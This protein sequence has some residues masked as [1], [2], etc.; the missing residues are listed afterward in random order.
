[1]FE[2]EN[3]FDAGNASY[4]YFELLKLS[5]LSALNVN[6]YLA[7]MYIEAINQCKSAALL[8]QYGI[9]RKYHNRQYNEF[10]KFADIVEHRNAVPIMELC[11]EDFKVYDVLHLSLRGNTNL[12]REHFLRTA[13]RRAAIER[14]L[15]LCFMV[16]A[17]NNGK[18]FGKYER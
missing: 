11:G 6:R 8:D 13:Y 5:P 9:N 10:Y 7:S 18:T 12:Y 4:S 14:W 3:P 2:I 17:F 15:N 16:D 1:M